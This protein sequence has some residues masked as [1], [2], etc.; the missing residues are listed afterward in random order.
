MKAPTDKRSKLEAP[1]TNESHMQK[2]L[3]VLLS[4][5]SSGC[6]IPFAIPPAKIDAS[7]GAQLS[8][9]QPAQPAFHLNTGLSLA[10]AQID[11]VYP[12]DLQVGYA[13]HVPFE[14]GTP[15]QGVYG[16]F[17]WFV[18]VNQH[19]RWELGARG[20]VLVNRFGDTGFGAFVHLGAEGF[21]ADTG[22]FESSSSDG[23]AFGSSYGTGGFS[24]FVDAGR[25]QGID[26]QASTFISG[27]IS[28]RIPAAIGLFIGWPW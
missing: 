2:K 20:E 26:A 28:F 10:S 21:T 25:L 24:L 8:Q 16:A 12:N 27:G 1:K 23:I 18:P 15:S 13:L 4:L 11:P 7:L 14:R 22:P 3:G 17:S 5:L 9:D 19:F 6:I